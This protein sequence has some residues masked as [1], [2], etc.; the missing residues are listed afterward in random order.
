M[1]T[2]ARSSTAAEAR[3][4]PPAMSTLAR[5]GDADH[6]LP[7]G[8]RV[9]GRL[10]QHAAHLEGAIAAPAKARHLGLVMLGR[11]TVGG[12]AARAVPRTAHPSPLARAV[13]ARNPHTR[14]LHLG[15]TH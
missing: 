11:Q 2:S 14:R 5:A 6:A 9:V 10:A 12:D 3:T 15:L 4:A 13:R 8:R 7:V 1:A